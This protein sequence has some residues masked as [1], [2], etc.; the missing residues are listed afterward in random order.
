MIGFFTKQNKKNGPPER[1]SYFW[2]KGTWQKRVGIWGRR[3]EGGG[4]IV[5][6]LPKKVPR[7]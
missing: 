4:D 1:R 7:L 3:R 2:V 5:E 6:F